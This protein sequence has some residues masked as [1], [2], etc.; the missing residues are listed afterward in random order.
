MLTNIS[1]LIHADHANKIPIKYQTKAQ[2]TI[3]EIA[4][5]LK[6]RLEELKLT[7]SA[8]NIAELHNTKES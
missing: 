8:K 7:E 1:D 4:T 3:K 5:Q 2:Q 6:N